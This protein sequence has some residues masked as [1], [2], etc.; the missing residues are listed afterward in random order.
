[1]VTHSEAVLCSEFD[2]YGKRL[3]CGTADH[4]VLIYD[5]DGKDWQL[6][7]QWKAH[8]APVYNCS[9][10]HPYFGSLLATCS[11]QV[12]VWEQVP[13]QRTP[14]VERCKLTDAR[15]V[16]DAVQFA[17]QP[18]G[19]K[20]ATASRDGTLRLYIPSE[21]ISLTEWTLIEELQFSKTDIENVKMS[22]SPDDDKLVTI[23]P[24]S[25]IIYGS[26]NNVMTKLYET[27]LSDKPIS[28]AFAPTM[29]RSFDLVAVG[30]N[31][32]RL[33]IYK[34]PNDSS[35]VTEISTEIL[36]GEISEIEWNI[37]GT[38]LLTTTEKELTK[39][40]KNS[41]GKWHT[42]EKIAYRE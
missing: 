20:L 1:M 36:N 29:G 14:F 34:V 4:K 8:T 7:T 12:I 9:L 11:D 6:V 5:H 39:W 28:C 17:P 27:T 25:V 38:E 22:Y 40:Q 10:S 31:E 15:G 21:L 26:S 23:F 41:E 3:V 16:V 18:V 24:N 42:I 2:F 19:L 35:E 13:N 33:F 32:G 37:T 30:T